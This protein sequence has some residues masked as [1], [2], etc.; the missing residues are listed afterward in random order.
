MKLVNSLSGLK[1]D[2]KENQ[3]NVIVIESPELFTEYVSEIKKQIAGED[4]QFVLSEKDICEIDKIM[5]LIVDPWSIDFDSK[6]IKTK[7]LQLV[8]EEADEYFYDKFIEAKSIVCQYAENVVDK[9][10]YPVSYDMNIDT[11]AFMKFL[12][13]KI[14][15]Q[16]EKLIDI[17]IE[18]I[19]L[20]HDLC[21]IEVIVFANVK[22][23]LTKD[24]VFYLYQVAQYQKI[25][26]I[27][28]EATLTTRM[29]CE[30]ITIIDADKCVINI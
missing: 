10:M 24:E 19:K 25:H 3:V 26:L 22:T 13:I 6:R 23:Y 28:L 8:K 4:G 9:I 29:Q 16:S 14:E 2:L 1:I 11:M 5:E 17:I 21:K 18:Y 12:D 27:M 20:L 7:L 30:I 15:I